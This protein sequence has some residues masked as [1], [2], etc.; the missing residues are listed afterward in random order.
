MSA[1]GCPNSRIRLR[2]PA[3]DPSVVVPMGRLYIAVAEKPAYGVDAGPRQEQPDRERIP[4]SMEVNVG[5]TGPPASR[6]EQ[7][8][9][10]LD[11]KTVGIIRLEEVPR[12]G[13]WQ[14]C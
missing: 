3:G 8:P 4:E 1:P 13:H 7:A 14:V 6:Q 9:V 11:R 2:L 10:S 12:P 5:D